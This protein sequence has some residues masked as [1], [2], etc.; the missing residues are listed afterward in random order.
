M[1]ATE[2]D[3]CFLAN[4][5][6]EHVV[7]AV[8]MIHTAVF[9]VVH[10]LVVARSLGDVILLG[11]IALYAPAHLLCYCLDEVY[12]NPTAAVSVKVS[13][14]CWGIV[15]VAIFLVFVFPTA[16]IQYFS[17]FPPPWGQNFK[18]F[19][20]KSAVFAPERAK[21]PRP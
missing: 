10:R 16:K 19:K 4:Y 18:K 21:K 11:F 15:I 7:H 12:I 8:G 13:G 9:H 14:I 1:A 5:L 6:L 20:A 17:G 3:E 2:F